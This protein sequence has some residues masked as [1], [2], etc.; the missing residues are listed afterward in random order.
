MN[1]PHRPHTYRPTKH[2][3]NVCLNFHRTGHHN[4]HYLHGSN[5]V[6]GIRGEVV[7]PTENEYWSVA[8]ED[9]S[10]SM[11][12]TSSARTYNPSHSLAGTDSKTRLNSHRSTTSTDKEIN[13][14]GDSVLFDNKDNIQ[15]PDEEGNV[16]DV[17]P[18]LSHRINIGESDIG[19]DE[20]FDEPVYNSISPSAADFPGHVAGN[21]NQQEGEY[22][23]LYKDSKGGI[24]PR[25]LHSSAEL[26]TKVNSLARR[27]HDYESIELGDNAQQ[28]NSDC[29]LKDSEVSQGV[30]R[31]S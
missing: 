29:V 9:E 3:S 23:H 2:T 11:P 31:G 17:N 28:N 30:A 5:G 15:I 14:L 22:D 25:S 7:I 20:C 18:V 6:D 10:L 8:R 19:Q 13:E 1:V 24:S 4:E 26:L 16:D 21:Q 12:I 27:D